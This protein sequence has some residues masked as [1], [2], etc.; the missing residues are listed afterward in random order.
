MSFIKREE[1]N[2]QQNISKLNPAIYKRNNAS[3]PKQ[4]IQEC[5]TRS[6]LKYQCNRLLKT[7]KEKLYYCSNQMMQKNHLIKSNIFFKAKTQ[8]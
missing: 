3:Q 4:P 1:K 6:A 5:K 7:I 8:L 2:T